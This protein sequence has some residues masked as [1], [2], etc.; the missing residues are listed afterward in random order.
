M[1]MQFALS[2]VHVS[3]AVL[4]NAKKTKLCVSDGFRVTRNCGGDCSPQSGGLSEEELRTKEEEQGT[5]EG[6]AAMEMLW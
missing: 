6:K 3:A 5:C 1:Q 2:S 4:Q